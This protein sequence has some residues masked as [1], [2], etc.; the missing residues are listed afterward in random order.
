MAQ[1][2]KPSSM[3]RENTPA[4][5]QFIQLASD[6]TMAASG[7]AGEEY[8]DPEMSRMLDTILVMTASLLSALQQA[9]QRASMR[10]MQPPAG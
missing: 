7:Y 10:P 4:V 6:L 3:L 5:N 2:P 9:Q 8:S 1:A